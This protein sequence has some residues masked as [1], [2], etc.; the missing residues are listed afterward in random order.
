MLAYTGK[1]GL[2]RDPATDEWVSVD[3]K[4]AKTLFRE[5][6]QIKILVGTD[7]L[8]E[9]LNLQTCGFV[10]NYDMPWNFIRVEQRIGRV[11]RIG[12]QR[13]VEVRNFFY[14]RT[15]EANIY[16]A[17]ATAQGGFDW[18]VGDAAPVLG[19]LEGLIQNAALAGDDGQPVLSPDDAP[20]Y[21]L[22]AL[23]VIQD[24]V[25]EAQA[26]SIRLDMLDEER[27]DF[28]RIEPNWGEALT[29]EDLRSI[30]VEVPA[31]AEQLTPHP[32]EPGLYF[33][34]DTS[35]TPVAVTFDREVL[36]KSSPKVRLLSYGDPLFDLVL[37][38]AGV[39]VDSVVRSE[40]DSPNGAVLT[41]A[42]QIG[43][44]PLGDTL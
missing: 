2:R 26:Q 33:V 23:S 20:K 22:R 16:K 1:G 28:A 8:S 34:E 21:A 41:I 11:D 43:E 35:G 5:G 18:I 39:D 19:S 40:P 31:T 9:G 37:A 10:L 36:D 25:A 15:V 42:E 30:L 4:T 27:G 24:Q 29:L 3:K 12:G 7:T 44:L 6:E 32:E 17:I 14:N 38:R 13:Q